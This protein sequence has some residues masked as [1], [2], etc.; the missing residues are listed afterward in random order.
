MPDVIGSPLPREF[1]DPLEQAAEALA[2]LAVRVLWRAETRSTN[3]DAVACAEAGAPEGLLVLADAQTAGRG[4]LGR[5]WSSPAGAGVYASVLLR[6]DLPIARMLPIAAGV[7]VAEGIEAATGL[8]PT[9]KWPNDVSLP[10][11][12]NTGRKVAGILIEGGASGRGAWA[13]VGF[14]INVL[15]SAL[16]PEIAPRATSLE[17]ELGR[18][19]DRG[20]LLAS[21]LARL[22]VRYA[23]LR[24]GRSPAVVEA[25]KQRASQ[26]FGRR[27]EWDDEAGVRGGRIRTIDDDGRLIV[28]TASGE[29]RI[30]SGE[31]RWA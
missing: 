26:T 9:L 27:V 8:A 6:P 25:W 22:A 28:E 21:C 24:A 15:P 4:R 20:V 30:V 17:S 2:P 11:G 13:V 1:A 14:G 3:A 19:V 16:P 23:D 5:L 12:S 18:A 31:V 29:A 7:A 10:S